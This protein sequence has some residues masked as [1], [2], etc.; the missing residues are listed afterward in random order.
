MSQKPDIHHPDISF[1]SVPRYPVGD[2]EYGD[3]EDEDNEDGDAEV[4]DDLREG[5][6]TQTI[7]SVI[8]PEVCVPVHPLAFVLTNNCPVPAF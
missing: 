3:D 2:D 6:S 1:T 4:S 7:H 8:P 5:L